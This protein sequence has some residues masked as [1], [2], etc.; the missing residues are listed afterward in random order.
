MNECR[1]FIEELSRFAHQTG[2]LSTGAEGDVSLMVDGAR[3]MF[4]LLS[5]ALTEE[6]IHEAKERFGV[7]AF[8][9]L[10]DSLQSLWSDIPAEGEWQPSWLESI[11]EWLLQEGKPGDLV[12]VQG[13]FG[14]TV[15][16]VNWLRQHGFRPVY[17]TSRRHVEEKRLDDGTVVAS[18]IF[19]HV[20]F[21]D[22]P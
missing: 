14:A 12:V 19:R 16:M 7:V 18:R 8:Y 15:Y 22:Y 20:Q 3:K 5:H 10:P 9:P 4:L 1:P 13:E 2:E 11:K 21:R 17:A 6:Q